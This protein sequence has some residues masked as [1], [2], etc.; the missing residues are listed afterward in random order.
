MKP[1]LSAAIL[2]VLASS[3]LAQDWNNPSAERLQKSVGGILIPSIDF[4]QTSGVECLEFIRSRIR[5]THFFE[6]ESTR[7]AFEYRCS[8]DRLMTA[9]S[10]KTTNVTVVKALDEVSEKLGISGAIGEGKI[11]FT[12]ADGV[13]RAKP[14]TP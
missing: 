5:D 2:L 14:G 3:L 11:V 6:Q 10:L 8:P 1:Y 9:L 13:N 4:E 7:P 12:N